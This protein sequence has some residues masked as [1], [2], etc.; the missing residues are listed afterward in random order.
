MSQTIAS[1]EREANT[2]PLSFPFVTLA[3]EKKVLFLFLITNLTNETEL[4][5]NYES[6]NATSNSTVAP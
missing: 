3:A 2:E 5:N 6:G 4:M 1:I